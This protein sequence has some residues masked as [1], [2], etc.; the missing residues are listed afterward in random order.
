MT[1]KDKY[2]AELARATRL[3]CSDEI[4]LVEWEDLCKQA[5]VDLNGPVPEGRTLL[6]GVMDHGIVVGHVAIPPLSPATWTS[7]TLDGFAKCP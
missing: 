7:K 1:T 5:W 3:I 2:D 4:E 6:A